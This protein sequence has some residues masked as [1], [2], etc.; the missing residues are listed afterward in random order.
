M[1]GHFYNNAMPQLLDSQ[2]FFEQQAQ[3]SSLKIRF[4]IK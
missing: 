2:A 1:K 4:A 3:L